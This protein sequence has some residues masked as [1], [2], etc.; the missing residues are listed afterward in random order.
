MLLLKIL[1][2]VG[3]LTRLASGKRTDSA[4]DDVVDIASSPASGLHVIALHTIQLINYIFKFLHCFFCGL[5][6]SFLAAA[7]VAM[8][9]GYLDAPVTSRERF[10]AAERI[11]PIWEQI[12]RV[13]GPE[14]FKHYELHA[15]GERRNDRERALEMLE[16]WAM[17]FGNGATR[18]QL[19]DAMMR[20]N[21]S[22]EV[23]EIFSGKIH[24][25]LKSYSI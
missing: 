24:L 8:Q 25:P 14:P 10:E 3:Q 9:Q 1:Y 7:V 2:T 22:T 21:Y 23:T 19:I 20:F 13:L 12:G 5:E 4:T 16:A 17:K 11:Q 18:E 15:F 6:F